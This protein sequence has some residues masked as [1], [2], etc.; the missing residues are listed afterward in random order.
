MLLPAFRQLHKQTLER[1]WTG[2][3]A[4]GGFFAI[5]IGVN[6]ASL[7]L[8]SL[9]LNQ[10]I[11][12]TVPVVSCLIAVLG[13]GKA[14]GLN[15]TLALLML[16]V[17][18][19]VASFDEVTSRQNLVGVALCLVGTISNGLTASFS[20]RVMS[21]KV[22]ALRLT[23]YASPVACL[24]LLPFHA[25]FE[26]ASLTA[27][28]LQAESSYVGLLLLTCVVALAYNVSHY[29]V[30]HVTT[31]TAMT[32]VGEM[33]IVLVLLL[34]AIMLGE[35]AIWTFKFVAGG[36]LAI[37]GFCLYSHE[38]LRAAQLSSV[39]V[40]KGVPELT[41]LLRQPGGGGGAVGMI[42]IGTASGLRLSDKAAADAFG[43]RP[44]GPGSG[45][46]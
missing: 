44:G 38:R 6:N 25:R 29:L 7:L 14:P 16:V 43:R 21:E 23:F 20:T 30:I 3:L 45:L 9:S 42:S 37:L 19:F 31:P 22:D 15:E 13:E 18:V 10:L 5:N 33:K 4:V 8:V 41:P 24:A 35:G 28:R 32:I 39:P 17:G 27:Y 26:Y 1:S 40:I 11:R 46:L 12:S 2:L 36:T 34:S